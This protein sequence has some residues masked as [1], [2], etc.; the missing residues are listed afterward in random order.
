M[1]LG[2]V[3]HSRQTKNTNQTA[4]IIESPSIITAKKFA[5]TIITGE[6]ASLL[7]GSAV[8]MEPTVS[9]STITTAT[10]VNSPTVG[11]IKMNDTVADD[12]A[13]TPASTDSTSTPISQEDL[14]VKSDPEEGP[15]PSS[16]LLITTAPNTKTSNP[17]SNDNPDWEEGTQ[18][19]PNSTTEYIFDGTDIITIAAT[20]SSGTNE[21]ETIATNQVK[22][23]LAS[24]YSCEQQSVTTSNVSEATEDDTTNNN[25]GAIYFRFNYE[26]YTAPNRTTTKLQEILSEFEL[27]LGYG[28]ASAVGLIDC[29]AKNVVDGLEIMNANSV[30]GKKRL[31]HGRYE[32]RSLQKNLE[33]YEFMEISVEPLDIIDTTLCKFCPL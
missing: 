13:Y 9:L 27:Q 25:K 28:V 20:A 10:T 22:K 5:V 4:P 8:T 14:L 29:S 18:P 30:D 3:G 16:N 11:D 15:I 26:I 6:M 33:G 32:R 1:H 24:S 31:R 19:C 7:N 21:E 2:R 23:E 17:C 12:K